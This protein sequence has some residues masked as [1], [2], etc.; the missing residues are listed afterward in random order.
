MPF[1]KSAA[2]A[3]KWSMALAKTFDSIIF[4]YGGV[5]VEH[6]TEKDHAAMA[7][8]AGME[9]LLFSE[10]YWASRLDYD[11]GVVTGAEYW[12]AIAKKADK[13]LTPEALERLTEID[14]TSWMRFDSVMWNWVAEL[15]QAG[16]PIAVLSNMPRDLGETLKTQTDRFTKFN[17]VTLSYEMQSVKPEPAIYEECLAGL[18][19][20]PERTV[21]LDDRIE[22]VQGAEL[23]GIQALQFVNRDD[24]LRKLRT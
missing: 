11:K 22:N 1:V 8:V 21:F 7:A 23:L 20:R 15:R 6:Q 13:L 5:L 4:D 17:N 2:G 9:P 16:K 12:Q 3:S 14:T 10:L 18:G 19:T 24:V